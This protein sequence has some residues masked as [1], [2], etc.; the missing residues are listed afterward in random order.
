MSQEKRKPTIELPDT[1]MGVNTKKALEKI[2]AETSAPDK[3][4]A[5]VSQPGLHSLKPVYQGL[6]E[7]YGLVFREAGRNIPFYITRDGRS[8]RETSISV[9]KILCDPTT[10]RLYFTQSPNALMATDGEKVEEI[11]KYGVKNGKEAEPWGIWREGD[12]VLVCL[13]EQGKIADHEGKVLHDNLEEPLAAITF[14]GRLYH[15]ENWGRCLVDTAKNESVAKCGKWAEGLDISIDGK[16]L[17]FGGFDK[18]VYSYDGQSQRQVADLPFSIWSI[19][20]VNEQGREVLY[21]GGYESRGITR[22]ELDNDEVTDKSV[23][24]EGKIENVAS[25]AAVPLDFLEKL[26]RNFGVGEWE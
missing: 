1:F 17:Y 4:Q 18:K 23:L 15:A 20:A 14:N 11:R 16:R 8:R 10:S 7:D 19:H 21:V 9:N 26:D 2:L 6:G 12:D 25:I 24:L 22:L 5:H 3:P 13:L